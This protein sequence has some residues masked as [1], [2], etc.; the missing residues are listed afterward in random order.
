MGLIIFSL[1]LRI[2]FRAYN[3]I[4]RIVSGTLS[5]FLVVFFIIIWNQT[6]METE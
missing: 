1:G 5:V 4:Y 3:L 6:P 2:F